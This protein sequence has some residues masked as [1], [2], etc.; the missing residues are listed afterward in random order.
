MPIYHYKALSPDGRLVKG[1]IDAGNLP[2]LE[3]RL[4]RQGLELISGRI[5]HYQPLFRRQIPRRDLINFCFHL[6]QMTQAGV[7]LLDTLRDLR[8]SL[9]NPQFSDVVAHLIESIEGGQTLSQ[10]MA[11]H[12]QVFSHVFISLMEAGEASGK[13]T[14]VL[15]S[16]ITVMK[17][18]DEL[19]AHT[20][21][22]L[23]YPSFVG[24]TVVL[25]SIFLMIF[26]VPQLKQFIRNMGQGL[27]LQT[28]ILFAVS[29]FL[30]AYWYLLPLM[31]L[32]LTAIFQFTL[33]VHPLARLYLDRSKLKLPF[34]GIILRKI[35]LARFAS[36][37]AMLYAAG[38][39]ILDA[40][41]ITR[42]VVGN[43]MITHALEQVQQTIGEGHNIAAAFERVR[44]F[45]P[46]VIRMLRV[47]EKTGAL[48]RALL[49]ISYFYNR[50][51]KESVE[52]VQV[53]I[54]PLLTMVFGAI[55]GWIM[56]AALGPIYDIISRVK[57]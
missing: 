49:N 13:L 38:I 29:D 23:I 53:M 46:L 33:R 1:R 27:P 6:Q 41:R 52:K 24:G 39:P 8:E 17:W 34:I 56:L 12:P 42:G 4:G 50:D 7:P 45:P 51:V 36:T 5:Q 14:E 22:L 21:K 44:L 47:G 54:E 15:D 32:L 3:M 30:V 35:I 19:S 40:I 28:K 26:M 25:V 10:A 55:L 18:E 2:D 9:E 57:I 16:E 48:D 31:I 11:L 37:F 20:K 43:Q